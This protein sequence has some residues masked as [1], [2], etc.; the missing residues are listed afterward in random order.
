METLIRAPVTADSVLTA[1]RAALEFD[2]AAV[3]NLRRIA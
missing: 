3:A 2:P 1:L